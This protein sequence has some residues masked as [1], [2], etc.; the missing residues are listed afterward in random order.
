MV[1]FL[2]L[3][4]NERYDCVVER[5]RSRDGLLESLPQPTLDSQSERPHNLLQLHAVSYTRLYRPIDETLADLS[6]YGGPS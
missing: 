5:D 4:A 1:E 2:Q 3:V 6:R